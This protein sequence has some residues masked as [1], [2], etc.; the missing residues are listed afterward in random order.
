MSKRYKVNRPGKPAKTISLQDLKD[1]FKKREKGSFEQYLENFL[2][3]QGYLKD[4][5]GQSDTDIDEW[6]DEVMEQENDRE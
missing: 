4:S 2:R 5:P 6:V 1:Y 3:E